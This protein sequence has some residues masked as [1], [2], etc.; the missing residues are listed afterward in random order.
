MSI[1][2]Q[3][4]PVNSSAAEAKA[5]ATTPQLR[6]ARRELEP[7]AWRRFLPLLR[8]SYG[9]LAIYAILAVAFLGALTI[10]I[11]AFVPMVWR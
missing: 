11:A 9:P 1:A 10:R 8:R 6:F 7:G 3:D 5:S 2:I 4:R